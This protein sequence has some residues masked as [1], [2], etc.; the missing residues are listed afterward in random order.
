M[1]I[2][3]LYPK[4]RTKP[5]NT[6]QTE[7]HTLAFPQSHLD[8]STLFLGVLSPRPWKTPTSELNSLYSHLLL[9]ASPCPRMSFSFYS[10][11]Y[12]NFPHF[13]FP[14]GLH[15]MHG[16]KIVSQAW[17]LICGENTLVF[18]KAY[19]TTSSY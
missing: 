3:R 8:V 11:S 14:H 18:R 15:D 4:R 19:S 1:N 2:F 17:H 5:T 12:R 10:L 7:K 16:S 13:T 9:G 6:K